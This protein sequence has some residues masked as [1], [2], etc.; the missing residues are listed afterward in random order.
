MLSSGDGGEQT[1]V[2]GGE[3]MKCKICGQEKEGVEFNKWVKDT[4]TNYDLLVGDG[5]VICDD[6]LFWFDQS[7]AELQRKMGKEIPQKM[8]NY[9]HFV[10][11]GEWIPV[12]KGNKNEMKRLLIEG[13]FP[14]MAVIAVSGQKHLAFRARRN[15]IGQHCGWVQFEEQSIWVDSEILRRLIDK[16]ENLYT[17]FSKSEIE[18]GKYAA[19]RIIKFG[20]ERWERLENEIKKERGKGLFQLALF[21]AQRS[22]D[23]NEGN[24]SNHAADDMAGDIGG[25]QKPISNDDLGAIRERDKIGGLHQQPAEVYQYSLFKI[26]QPAGKDGSGE[27]I[28]QSNYPGSE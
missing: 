10:V 13:E 3:G 1:K 23:G 28:I 19:H 24:D 25:L 15:P 21:L 18:S 5:D 17:T 4:F 12:G 2:G 7:S 9:S 8:Q 26:A 22:E 14:E 11:K 27:V 6:C 16:V 20:F